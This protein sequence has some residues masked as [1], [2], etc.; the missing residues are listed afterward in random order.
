[1]ITV[2]GTGS[3]ETI[4][5]L[6]IEDPES[7]IAVA[8][9]RYL[10]KTGYWIVVA[11]A[12]LSMLSALYANLLAASRVAQSMAR[13]RTLP[14]TLGRVDEKRGTPVN[15]VLVTAAIIALTVL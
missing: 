4:T 8:A 12:I 3:G 9:E 15:A 10:G 1:M 14:R 13:D 6:S 7:I 11:A 5:G 2:S